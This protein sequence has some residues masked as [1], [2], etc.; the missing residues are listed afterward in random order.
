MC[1]RNSLQ[2]IRPI[3]WILGSKV[4]RRRANSDAVPFIFIR[5]RR[6][7]P[8][9]LSVIVAG[10]SS[11][12]SLPSPVAMAW[13]VDLGKLIQVDSFARL[14]SRGSLDLAS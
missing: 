14:V 8:L 12:V 6:Q 10:P 5:V 2:M 9:A 13:P 3:A 1:P 4:L 11:G 7:S